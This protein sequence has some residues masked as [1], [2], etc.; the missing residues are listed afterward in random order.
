[1]TSAAPQFGV[2]ADTLNAIV[3]GMGAIIFAVARQLPPENMA[4]FRSDLNR[5]AKARSD[6][7]DTTGQKLIQELVRAL[8]D[9]E[10]TARPN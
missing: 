3:T 2:N 7:N 8:D 6:A 4:R 10:P 9:A 1:M 5:M